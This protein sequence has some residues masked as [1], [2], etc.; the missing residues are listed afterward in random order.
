MAATSYLNSDSRKGGDIV[1]MS[2]AFFVGQ[3]SA[4]CLNHSLSPLT[5]ATGSR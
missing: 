4:S 3:L 2:L 5:G 1:A